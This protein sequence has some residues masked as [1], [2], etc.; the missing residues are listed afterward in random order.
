LAKNISSD[1]RTE[2]SGFL[3]PAFRLFGGEKAEIN[4]AWFKRGWNIFTFVAFVRIRIAI[5]FF[6]ADGAVCFHFA[7]FIQTDSVLCF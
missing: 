7:T 2:D 5:L 6:S 1:L 4:G 3:S